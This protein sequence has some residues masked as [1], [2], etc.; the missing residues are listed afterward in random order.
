MDLRALSDRVEIEDLL[1]R[2]AHAVDTR[3]W[4]LYR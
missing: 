2:Y 4:D 3:N 1:T